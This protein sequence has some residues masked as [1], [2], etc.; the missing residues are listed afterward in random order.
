M[1]LKGNLV[2]YLK[3]QQAVTISVI[4]EHIN[5]RKGGIFKRFLLPF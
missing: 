2:H 3:K 4:T 1:S 5:D